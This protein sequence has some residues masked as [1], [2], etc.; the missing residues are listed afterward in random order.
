MSAW[1][2]PI[3]GDKL[4]NWE[5]AQ[6]NSFWDM[7]KRFNI[8]QGDDVFF[9]LS[10]EKPKVAHAGMA[11]WGIVS[12]GVEVVDP[13]TLPWTD[14][15]Y[16]YKY[17]FHFQ[18]V[19]TQRTVD[20]RWGEAQKLLGT[21][22]TAQAPREFQT[23]QQVDY[24][25]SLFASQTDRTIGPYATTI[26]V[27][28]SVVPSRIDDPYVQGEDM[29]KRA[30]RLIVIRQGQGAF[31]K[32]LMDNYHG[33]CA[34]TATSVPSVLEAAH[35]DRYFGENTHHVT[36]GLLLRADLHTLFD[37]RRITVD[38][39]FLIRVDPKLTGTEYESLDGM[40]LR[41][42][43]NLA[44]HP[45]RGALHRHRESCSWMPNSSATT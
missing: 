20:P 3:D 44:H 32:S 14:P 25:R 36:N 5:I 24:L 45:D 11:G 13:S 16:G 23:T 34:M 26:T 18:V 15:N 42:P 22:F 37:L 41:L 17:R 21:A 29:R 10:G 33:A 12:S 9:W 27:D 28:S 19:N 7:P 6:A 38:E 1:I 39:N 43:A 40:P 30:E 8:Q 2:V 4:E 35:I 31:R